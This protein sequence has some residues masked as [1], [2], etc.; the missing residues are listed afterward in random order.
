MIIAEYKTY[1]ENKFKEYTDA[2]DSSNPKIKLKIEH[3]YRVAKL[4]E[5]IA[6]SLGLSEVD[7]TVAWTCGMLHDIGRF[8]QVK[9]YG[10]FFDS[11]SVDHAQFGAD[12]LFCQG[13]YEQIVPKELVD[14][15]RE[16]IEKAIRVHN[17]FRIPE[18]MSER[19]TMYANILRDAD[20]IDI[21]KVNCETP[22]EDVYNC[23]KEEFVSSEVSEDVRI[24]FR[25]HRCAKRH[26]R[27][28]AIDYLVGHVCLVFELVYP[29][30]VQIADEQGYI[31]TVLGFKSNNPDTQ[32]W[33]EY[34]KVEMRDYILGRIHHP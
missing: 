7:V 20:K 30:S 6:E 9:Q 24:A 11:I 13:L 27:T 18:N 19:E 22:P 26:Q 12:I 25:E 23:P 21:L 8:E 28:T 29:R 33:F 17:L 1:I 34:M 3:T 5:D 4:C 10:T 15:Q 14:G 31:Y 2:Y 16:L 32:E